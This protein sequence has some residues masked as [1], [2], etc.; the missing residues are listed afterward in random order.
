MI[1]TAEL[2]TFLRN[3]QSLCDIK[4][5]HTKQDVLS[6]FGAQLDQYGEKDYGYFELPRGIRFSFFKDEI[7]GLA[8]LNKRNDAVFDLVVPDLQDT[9]TIGPKTTIQEAI[10][11]LNW[12]QVNWTVV[13]T[14]NK[15]NLTILTQGNVGL[16]FDLDDGELMMISKV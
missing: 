10:K 3:G 16:I 2:I 7:D 11:F 5:G 13:D 8:V 1:E 6:K 9:F 4:I 14:V 15:F 12:S